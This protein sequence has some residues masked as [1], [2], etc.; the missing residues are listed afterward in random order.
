MDTSEPYD[1]Q[2]STPGSSG[3][4]RASGEM[5]VSSERTGA[6]GPDRDTTDGTKDTSAA[7]GDTPREDLPPEQRPDLVE[8]NPEGL[9]PKAGYPAVD[10]RSDS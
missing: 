1:V 5:G 2:D 10:P 6:A 9:A 7:G 4:D 3:P 8:E